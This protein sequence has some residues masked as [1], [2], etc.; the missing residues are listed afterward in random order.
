MEACAQAFRGLE[1]GQR[2]G[3]QTHEGSHIPEIDG[4]I[5]GRKTAEDFGYEPVQAPPL[6]LRVRLLAEGG[7][8]DPHR[9]ARSDLRQGRFPRGGFRQDGFRQG[10]LRCGRLPPGGFPRSGLREG[11][12]DAEPRGLDDPDTL[13][14]GREPGP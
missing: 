13:P 14:A 5:A 8:V 2:P 3:E 10:G 4:D 7:E 11:G 9:L 6:G 1:V 12:F